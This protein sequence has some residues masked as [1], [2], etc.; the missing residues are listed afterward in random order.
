MLGATCS[1]T[2]PSFAWTALVRLLGCGTNCLSR[3]DRGESPPTF[4]FCGK[5]GYSLTSIS[6]RNDRL[7]ENFACQ[8]RWKAKG[9]WPI[10]NSDPTPLSI[11]S[12][13]IRRAS[14]SGS[15]LGTGSCF[16][17]NARPGLAVGNMGLMGDF[18]T[19]IRRSGDRA[20]ASNRSVIFTFNIVYAVSSLQSCTAGQAAKL[21]A[22]ANALDQNVLGVGKQIREGK[23]TKAAIKQ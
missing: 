19:G 17:L 18:L 22:N 13:C 16:L 20:G 14:P 1:R 6:E 7:L 21:I 10:S 15:E 12:A 2:A 23:K 3:S 9:R 8:N 5:I 4:A 11:T